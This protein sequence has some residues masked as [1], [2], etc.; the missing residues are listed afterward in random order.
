MMMMLFGSLMVFGSRRMSMCEIF[1]CEESRDGNHAE[2]YGFVG[3]L[4]GLYLGL[5]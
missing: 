2:K 1:K 4:G 5:V 3:F